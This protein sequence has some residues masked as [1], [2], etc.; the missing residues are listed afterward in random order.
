M[1]V[2]FT[3]NAEAVAVD[4]NALYTHIEKTISIDYVS[5][6]VM[7]VVEMQW[8]SGFING[9]EN[10]D[11]LR[12]YKSASGIMG[13]ATVTMGDLPG[14]FYLEDAEDNRTYFEEFV[15]DDMVAGNGR[16][17]TVFYTESYQNIITSI[18]LGE[19]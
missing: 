11:E 18:D 19:E 14:T 12:D 5:E 6:S 17:V 13:G 16:Q 15:T 4:L 9:T 1:R 10:R 8:E 2:S 3:L 7:N